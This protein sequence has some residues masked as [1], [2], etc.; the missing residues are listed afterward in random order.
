MWNEEG[1]QNAQLAHFNKMTPIQQG[2]LKRMSDKVDKCEGLCNGPPKEHWCS[3]CTKL[4]KR[5]KELFVRFA[6]MNLE[7]ERYY[8]PN[9]S[10]GHPGFNEF[11]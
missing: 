5:Y 10:T 1:M 7:H 11:T 3:T 6:E 9:D 2:I 4:L 8:P